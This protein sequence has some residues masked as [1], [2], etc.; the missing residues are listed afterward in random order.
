MAI[1][2]LTSDWGLSDYYV[3][4]VKGA[5]YSY[6]PQAV[7]VDITHN[8]T[9]FDITKAGFI[10]KN[11]YK[12][13]PKGTIHILGVD[14]EESDEFPHVVVKADD[15]YFIGCDNGIFSIIL[16]DTPYEAFTIEVPQDTGFFTFSSRDRFAKV[17]GMIATGCDLSEIGDPYNSMKERCMLQPTFT[18]DSIHGYA[19]YI[20]NYQNVITNISKELFERVRNKRRFRISFANMKHVVTEINN[21]YRD[22]QDVLIMALFGTH[23]FLEIAVNKANAS[24]LLGLDIKSDIY[25]KFINE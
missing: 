9:Q 22:A 23:G 24:G 13:F 12:N 21:C 14:T 25:V 2:T 1:I 10:V 19:I 3:A 20:D 11:C 16:G 4:A 8:I 17:A 15:Q 7:I 18:S 6:Y 5:I